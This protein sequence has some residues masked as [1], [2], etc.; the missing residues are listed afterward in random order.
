MSRRS[1]P[2]IDPADLRDHADEAR[3][4]RV[5]ERIEHDLASRASYP[6]AGAHQRHRSSLAYL[7]IAAAF[8][9]FGGGLLLGKV[10]WDRRSPSLAP[11][12]SPVVEKSQVEVLAA[13][14]QQRTFPLQG[15]GG[16]TLSP[17]ATVEVE[18]SGGALTLSLLQGEASVDSADRALTILA[19]DARINTQ[20]GSV[21]SVRRNA[22][23][24]DVKVDDGSVTVSSPA[25][26]GQLA[27]N[28]RATVP[29]R[30]A[31]SASRSDADV[32]RERERALRPMPRRGA[33]PNLA[34]LA[35]V[36]E[37]FTHY[38]NDGAVAVAFL[39]KQGVDKAIDSARGAA[40]LSA[41]AE[42]MSDKDQA[43]ETRALLRLVNKFSSDQHA[44]LAARRL[45]SIYQARGDA[46]RAQ[47]FRDKVEPLAKNA[48]TGGDALFCNAIRHEADK[49][50]AAVMAKE[51]L[52]KYPDGECRDEFERQVQAQPDAPAAV[53]APAG[54]PSDVGSALPKAPP[55]P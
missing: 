33:H 12:A 7:A 29:L 9:A 3:V 25:G 28:Q 23:D 51:Y 38:P 42:L 16:L 45:A 53:G 24:V 39:R 4:E 47:E 17:G 2:R 15:G 8:G 35:N 54:D 34:K 1:F 30:A 18:R 11:I 31:V 44:F 21:L 10:T 22:D 14:T 41:I 50:K 43:A 6:S 37:W 19:G 26:P 48:T 13:G 36:P 20:S 46:A 40:E 52:D 5:W 32:R 55:P 49:T 27:K